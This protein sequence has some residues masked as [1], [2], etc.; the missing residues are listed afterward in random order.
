MYQ[1]LSCYSGQFPNVSAAGNQVTCRICAFLKQ[2]LLFIY[3]ILDYMF[4]THNTSYFF[5]IILTT[6]FNN[7]STCNLWHLYLK[8]VKALSHMT[9]KG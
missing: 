9:V 1:S 8:H 2:L 4:I 3:L 6:E 5:Q 7:C